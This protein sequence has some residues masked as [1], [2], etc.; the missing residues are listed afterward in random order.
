MSRLNSFL[1]GVRVLDLSRYVPGPLASLL[2]ADM[3]AEV[4]KIEPPSG[5]ELQH[6][7][8][9][10]GRRP[11][12][13]EA[14]NAGK[15]VLALDL[16]QPT[17][18]NVLLELVATADVLIEGFRPGAM[19]RL[20]LDY[21]HLH[22]INPRLIYCSINGYGARGPMALV[23]GHDSNYLALA[24]VLARNGIDDPIF[25]DPP[26]SDTAG[27]LFA[28]IAILGALQGRARTG[29]GC[30]IDLALA[31][32]AMPLQLLQLAGVGATDHA[33]DREETY[34]NG[35]AAYYRVYRT[36]D[37]RHIALGAVEPK[38]WHAFCE[39]AE[40]SDWV[41]RQSEPT[42]QKALIRE[43]AAY[44]AVL[45]LSEC[46]ARFQGADCCFSP[47]LDLAEALETPHLRHRGVVRRDHDGDVQALFPGLVDGAA[48][49][50]RAKLRRVS[51]AEACLAFSIRGDL[52]KEA[53]SD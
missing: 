36:R 53:L 48:P 45:T 8:P 47:V 29:K 26:I 44:F 40:R 5:D 46:V 38:F 31:D 10:P 49:P 16:K 32:V 35:G 28:M 41:A 14:I 23:A 9:R 42:P 27:S 39:A 19:N 3:G 20:G 2:L 18:K 7:G 17:D 6:L 12:F 37:D 34:L 22:P 52:K 33:P 21:E 30:A 51:A 15:A 13:Y 4:L 24:G 1:R 50:L 11:V 25:F 43:V